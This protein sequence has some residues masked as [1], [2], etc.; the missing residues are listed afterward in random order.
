MLNFLSIQI[1]DFIG[2]ES[3]F[4]YL[5][6]AIKLSRDRFLRSHVPSPISSIVM[7][8]VIHP[9]SPGYLLSPASKMSMASH[10]ALLPL[11]L[12][13]PSSRPAP[14]LECLGVLEGLTVLLLLPL[15][16]LLTVMTTST[17]ARSISIMELIEPPSSNGIGDLGPMESGYSSLLA[18]DRA[19]SVSC[20][21][22]F[23]LLSPSLHSEPEQNR[24][25]P[26][27]HSQSEQ[28]EHPKDDVS[29]RF[30]MAS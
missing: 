2:N 27:I 19:C 1:P 30:S 26:R 9:H 29:V 3:E 14:S 20:R 11:S 18:A 6:T 21:L 16:L 10:S 24:Q 7:P 13:M 25:L 4:N 17:S 28:L 22:S 12:S 5:S 15:L 23:A 8:C